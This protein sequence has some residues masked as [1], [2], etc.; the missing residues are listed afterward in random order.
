VAGAQGAGRRPLLYHS[1]YPDNWACWVAAVGGRL[2]AD[3]RGTGF[4]LVMNLIE[5]ARAGMGVAVVQ[6]CMVEADLAG[7]RLVMPVPGCASTGRGYYL[8]RPRATPGTR[9]VEVFSQW[10]REQAQGR[11]G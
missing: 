7:G 6:R 10:V 11:A 8:C 1:N 3:W 2:P 5:A 4:D 9:A